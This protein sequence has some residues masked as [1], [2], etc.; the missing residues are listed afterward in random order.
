MK[1]R[2]PFIQ[3][4]SEILKFD[5]VFAAVDFAERSNWRDN[6]QG[7]FDDDYRVDAAARNWRKG[8]SAI[9]TARVQEWMEKLD[10]SLHDR[11][12]MT[13]QPSPHG[14]YAVVPEYLANEPF[15]MRQKAR[16]ESVRAPITVWIELGLSMA[17]STEQAEKRAAAIAA[18]L[19]KLSETRAVEAKIICVST[20]NRSKEKFVQVD[21]DA[22]TFDATYITQALAMPEIVR[23]LRWALICENERGVH[24]VSFAYYNGHSTD[25]VRENRIREKFGAEPQDIVIQAAVSN[26]AKALQIINDPLGWVHA[27]IEKQRTIE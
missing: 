5:S 23:P 7:V 26:D 9:Q 12:V 20:V 8:P 27:Q 13:W 25:Q 2:A 11:E 15:N 1:R 18:L 16:E 19:M 10:A 22:K 17:F 21:I 14:A 4:S 24:S 6:A 3:S